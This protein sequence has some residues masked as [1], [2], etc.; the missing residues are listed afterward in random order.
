MRGLITRGAD[1]QACA[2][3]SESERVFIPNKLLISQISTLFTGMGG[4]KDWNDLLCC[5]VVK[6]YAIVH[7]KLEHLKLD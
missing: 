5:L 1:Y 2:K 6:T 3:C 7:L 4:T